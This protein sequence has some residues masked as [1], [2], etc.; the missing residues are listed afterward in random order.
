VV[1]H[2]LSSESRVDKIKKNEKKGA[3]RYIKHIYLE[4]QPEG[5][6]WGIEREVLCHWE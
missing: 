3:K 4:R 5:I 2:Q 1:Y 6:A